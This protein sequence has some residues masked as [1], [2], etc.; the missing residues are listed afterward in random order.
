MTEPARVLAVVLSW[1]EHDW[2][3]RAVASLV[4]QDVPT[5]ILVV[6]NASD[7]DPTAQ[8]EAL[9]ERVRVVRNPSN[10]G[11]AGGRNV[12]LR[13]ALGGA[14]DWVLIFDNDA[15]A[16][17][18]MVRSL[19][20]EGD[21]GADIGL[22][23]PRIYRLDQPDVIWRVGSTSWRWTYLHLGPEVLDR[24]WKST[25]HWPRRFLDTHR[26][27]DQRDE[28]QF[29]RA[30][31]IDFQIGCVQ[32]IR[33]DALREVGLLDEDFSPYG[34]ED[35]DFCAR[36][37]DRGW[38]IRYAPAG[39]AWHRVVS[40]FRG[41]YK[42][43]YFNTRHI[44]LL[45]RKRLSDAY[46]WGVFVPEWIALGVPLRLIEATLHGDVDRRRAVVDA[47]R[48]NVKDALARGRRARGGR[49]A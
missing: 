11:V 42:R 35:I 43:T 36:L 1:N 22:V 13:E 19:L 14:W 28:G 9:G 30:E 8:L 26:G 7:E 29:D 16:A 3:T 47:V 38:R 6:D 2:T 31:D 12:G 49:R 20:A 23:G 17:P 46:F 10:L 48:W 32:L 5:D 33:V 18:D 27:R 25:G 15:E 21:A 37:R 34:S 41:S 24:L 40:S 4:A 45:A 44:I 39:R